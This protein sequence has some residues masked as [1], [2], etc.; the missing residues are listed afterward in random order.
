MNHSY[1]WTVADASGHLPSAIIEGTL[2][3]LGDYDEC[4]ATIIPDDSEFETMDDG[5]SGETKQVGGKYCLA[6][7]KPHLPPKT[8]RVVKHSQPIFNFTGTELEGSVFEHMAQFSSAMYAL[9]GYRLGI[10]IPS[11]CHPQDVEI[12]TN[13]CKWT[14]WLSDS[15][16]LTVWSIFSHQRLPIESGS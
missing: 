15:S 3:D 5:E 9:Q 8:H 10:C 12:L 14:W 2:S 4:L 1:I 11:T 6:L 13:T 16:Y 7:I